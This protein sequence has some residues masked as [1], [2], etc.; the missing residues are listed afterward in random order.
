M[1]LFP[2]HPMGY[3]IP[4][5]QLVLLGM[6]RSLFHPTTCHRTLLIDTVLSRFQSWKWHTPILLQAIISISI[7][8]YTFPYH[9]WLWC[10]HHSIPEAMEHSHSGGIIPGSGIPTTCVGTTVPPPPLIP[11]NWNH[12]CYTSE[13][14]TNTEP[15]PG[16][17]P[18]PRGQRASWDPP[19]MIPPT[20]IS[21]VRLEAA[22][23]QVCYVRH[24]CWIPVLLSPFVIGSK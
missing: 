10:C 5:L 6:V 15:G 17:T 22:A 16:R 3:H 20:A 11:H 24:I 13:V 9:L 21:T 23:I 14:K 18:P 7:P 8:N 4:I 12:S 1:V 19:G 2:F